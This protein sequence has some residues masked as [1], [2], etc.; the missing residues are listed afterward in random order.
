MRSHVD[1]GDGEKATNINVTTTA[2]NKVIVSLLYGV[3]AKIV[4]K[5]EKQTFAPS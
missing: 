2:M 4:P 3:S 1:L 5:S